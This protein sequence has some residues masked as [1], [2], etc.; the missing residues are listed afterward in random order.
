MASTKKG[1]IS[2]LKT[3]SIFGIFEIKLLAFE[4]FRMIR[5]FVLHY[6]TGGYE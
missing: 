4:I 1:M 2:T 5:N 6:R 3:V